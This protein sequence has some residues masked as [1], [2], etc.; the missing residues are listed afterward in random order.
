MGYSIWLVRITLIVNAASS[1]SESCAYIITNHG[2]RARNDASCLTES[3]KEGV[4]PHF[5]TIAL[6]PLFSK[7]NV[8][9]FKTVTVFIKE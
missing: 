1:L 4:E 8:E 5:T 7:T 9:A 6:H 2:R 3:F